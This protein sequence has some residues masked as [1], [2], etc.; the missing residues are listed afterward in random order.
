[1]VTRYDMEGFDVSPEEHALGNW[2]KVQD[3]EELFEKYR[4]L[5]EKLEELQREG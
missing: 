4:E 2:V 1:M 3:Y 5:C